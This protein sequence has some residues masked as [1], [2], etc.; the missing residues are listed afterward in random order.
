MTTHKADDLRYQV[1]LRARLHRSLA[2][3][4]HLHRLRMRGNDLN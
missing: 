3:D 4:H 1:D 2:L